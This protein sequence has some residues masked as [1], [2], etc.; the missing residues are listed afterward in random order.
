MKKNVLFVISSTL[1]N[2]GVAAVTMKIVEALKETFVFD[3]IVS[4]VKPGF[5]DKRF[6]SYG[7][8]IIRAETVSYRQSKIGIIKNGDYIYKAVLRACTEKE[9]AVIHCENGF[10]SGP[11]I[12][13]AQKCG[14]PIRIVHAHGTY[15]TRGKNIFA[16]IYRLTCKRQIEEYSTCRLACSKKSGDSLFSGRFL[17]VL[18][19]LDVDMYQK[20]NKIEHETINL[21]QIGYYCYL[22]N[23]LFSLK[24]LQS[25]LK[26]GYKA[27]LYY[28]GFD[29]GSGYYEKVKKQ[30][31]E[32]ELDDNV[33][34]L[35][36]DYPKAELMGKIDFLL[37]PSTSEGLPLVTLEAQ[38]AN[39]YSLISDVVSKDVDMG[40]CTFL[41]ISDSEEWADQIVK[42]N[43]YTKKANLEK[44]ENIRINNYMKRI[45][46]IYMGN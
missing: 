41:P 38:A 26:R 7:G 4:G 8:R 31:K 5:Y 44:L 25:L 23:Q 42:L 27:Q 18:N 1:T 3:V 35:P 6:L 12:K 19:P 28:I 32:S 40:L 11:A 24:I 20:I 29:D 45:K 13:A 43:G 30:V 2:G 14:V 34:M 10:E 15:S 9:Y 16:K 37:L 46:E 21:L 33:F 22:K 17:N 39:V 36:S